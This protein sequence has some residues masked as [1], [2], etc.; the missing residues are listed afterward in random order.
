V[1]LYFANGSI[2]AN[3]SSNIELTAP[4]S[5]NTSNGDVANML[6]WQSASNSSSMIV[7]SDS[8]SYYNGV[9]Y[10]PDAQLTMNSSS[11]ATLN[12]NAT[13][14]ALD[15]QSVIF[16]SNINLAINSSGGYLGGVGKELGS[17]ALAE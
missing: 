9:I 6:I 12:S 10:L 16:N 2:T 14:T 4:S 13:A 1:T 11:S 5:G 17:F 15:V 7:N 8:S 3:S